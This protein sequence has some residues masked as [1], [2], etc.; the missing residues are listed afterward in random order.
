MVPIRVIKMAT[1]VS[2]EGIGIEN[3]L[4]NDLRIG[5]CDRWARAIIEESSYSVKCALSLVN[6]SSR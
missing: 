4:T 1:R 3:C 5:D 6:Y 2:K